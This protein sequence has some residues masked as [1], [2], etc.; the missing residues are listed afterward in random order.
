[1]MQRRESRKSLVTRTALSLA[2]NYALAFA[3]TVLAGVI[4]AIYLATATLILG[5]Y[6]GFEASPLSPVWF[7][8]AFAIVT[9]GGFASVCWETLGGARTVFCAA[10]SDDGLGAHRPHHAVYSWRTLALVGLGVLLL[11][12]GMDVPLST[13][14]LVDAQVVWR[15]PATGER[16]PSSSI[17]SDW[18]HED[19]YVTM[20][21]PF[22]IDDWGLPDSTVPEPVYFDAAG[23]S[24]RA[25][26]AGVDHMG[27]PYEVG[28]EL[29][30][31]PVALPEAGDTVFLT[32]R[33]YLIGPFYWPRFGSVCDW[34]CDASP[35]DGSREWPTGR[36]ET[37]P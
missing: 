29:H 21:V 6:A 18:R 28:H 14:H 17:V 36:A 11:L 33:R 7:Q 19:H 24:R 2:L 27:S 26:A 1:M 4:A 32:C 15:G 22:A 3:A 9:V 12:R 25:F 34:W 13:T 35:G 20:A 23:C 10:L 31:T 16:S 30:E 5:Y 37:P 8:A